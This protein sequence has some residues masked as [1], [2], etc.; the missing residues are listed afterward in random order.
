M[1]GWQLFA[2]KRACDLSYI[3]AVCRKQ[4]CGYC[5]ATGG[6]SA[7]KE[8]VMSRGNRGFSD[9]T[10]PNKW[11]QSEPH[12]IASSFGSVLRPAEPRV[13]LFATGVMNTK[14]L[15]CNGLV[16]Y[17]IVEAGQKRAEKVS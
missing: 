10:T 5:L 8:A 9:K 11:L 12:T 6:F 17:K 15:Y 4:E 2:E 13:M 3:Q 1:K 14:P 7:E 16:I